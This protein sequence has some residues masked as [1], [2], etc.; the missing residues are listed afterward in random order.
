MKETHP[1]AEIF[2]DCLDIIKNLV[3]LADMLR[4]PPNSALEDMR[5]R[6][7]ARARLATA[8]AAAKPELRNTAPDWV[9][10]HIRAR[11]IYAQSP[12]A[13]AALRELYAFFSDP[14]A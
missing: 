8:N 10:A 9:L 5:D 13:A 3:V 4:P 6:V 12:D 14:A 11:L 2:A 7:V 1:A